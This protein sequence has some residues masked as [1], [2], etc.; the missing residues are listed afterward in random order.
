MA[1]RVDKDGVYW[2]EYY[3]SI[4]WGR[5][6]RELGTRTARNAWEAR[7]QVRKQWPRAK[8]VK[9]VPDS[10]TAAVTNSRKVIIFDCTATKRPNK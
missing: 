3:V 1:P 5:G 4:P 2:F 6:W 8:R 7:N 10:L 9:V